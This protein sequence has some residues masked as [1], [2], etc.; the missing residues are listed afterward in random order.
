M[1]RV[2]ISGNADCTPA[3]GKTTRR[4]V[5]HRPE[6]F[7]AA[8]ADVRR[9]VDKTKPAGATI[10]VF[11]EKDVHA[12][13][14]LFARVYPDQSWHSQ[15]ACEAYFHE[16]LFDNPWRDLEIPSWVAEENGRLSG[17]Y[18]V[19]PRRMLLHG[20]PIR[21]AAACQFMVD[22]DNRNSLTALQLTQAC[23]SGPQDLTLADGASAQ[24]RRMWGAIGGVSALLYSLHWTRLL[25]PAH[26][27]LSLMEGVGGIARPLMHAARPLCA[28]AD[29]LAS[30]LAPNRFLRTVDDCTEEALDAAAMSSHLPG[31]MDGIALQPV[32]DTASLTW[33]LKQASRKKRHG[34]LRSRAVFD[35]GHKLIGWYL[36][37]LKDGGVGEVVQ[38][39]ALKNGFDR[40]LKRLLAD[41][42]NKGASAL[43]GRLDPRFAQEL[44]DRHCW[45]RRDDSWTLFH[46]RHAGVVAAIER[47]D[48]FLSRL[49]G[50]WWLRFQGG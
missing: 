33:L 20:R 38:I 50:E 48:A 26:Y 29:A 19:M 7:A 42:W 36:Y 43:R 10:R 24:A 14:A 17:F 25:R 23:L 31:V 27:A 11:E 46:S 9:D 44:S 32:Y 16:L 37:Y 22:P 4:H 40:V 21:V 41:A 13:A 12:A 1:D 15:G 39:A 18:A 45:M 34:E 3:R 28:V 6:P 49:E 8:V 30:R 47:G 5:T 2:A 35:A